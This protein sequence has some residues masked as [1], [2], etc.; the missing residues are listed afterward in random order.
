[1]NRRARHACQKHGPLRAA[2][3][4]IRRTGTMMGL[5]FSALVL[6]TV[7]AKSGAERTNPV[8]WFPVTNG[9]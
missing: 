4:R 7:G 3:R 6:T 9:S 5:G 2:A 1:V 8:G